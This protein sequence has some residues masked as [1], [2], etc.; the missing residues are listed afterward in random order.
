MQVISSWQNVWACSPCKHLNFR[1]YIQTPQL[2]PNTYVSHHPWMFNPIQLSHPCAT[3]YAD[4]TE[5][6]WDLFSFQ[7]GLSREY[8]CVSG[9]CKIRVLWANWSNIFSLS[10]CLVV[11]SIRS[12]TNKLGRVSPRKTGLCVNHLWFETLI[13]LPSPICHFE[14]S[15]IRS[16]AARRLIHTLYETHT[17]QE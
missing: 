17:L 14:P 2:F 9:N 13:Y 8:N 6:F 4:L 10:H 5:N 1:R 11:L 12:F 16:L 7:T 3:W 15:L